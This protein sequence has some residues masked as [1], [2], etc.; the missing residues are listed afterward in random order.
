MSSNKTNIKTKTNKVNVKQTSTEDGSDNIME[1][2]DPFQRRGSVSQS[3]PQMQNR[4]TQ[5]ITITEI[6]KYKEKKDKGEEDRDEIMNKEISIG[7]HSRTS[8]ISSHDEISQAL[9]RK[10][11]DMEIDKDNESTINRSVIEEIRYEREILESYLFND[12]NKISESAIKFIL[13]KW[14]LVEFRLQQ[15]HLEKEKI[16]AIHSEYVTKETVKTY[17]QK[18]IREI[19]AYTMAKTGKNRKQMTMTKHKHTVFL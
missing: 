17:A 8:S 19:Q 15:E 4:P 18:T 12:N 1:Q 16:V 5:G 2:E 3:Q 6:N 10:R 7:M 14:A 13:S 11:N 9:K